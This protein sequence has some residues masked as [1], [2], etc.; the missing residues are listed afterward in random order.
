MPGFPW[1]QVRQEDVRKPEGKSKD[2]SDAYSAGPLELLW[3]NKFL[4]LLFLAAWTELVPESQNIIPY[5][6]AVLTSVLSFLLMWLI[7]L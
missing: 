6:S 1:E 5:Q 3:A 2:K 4:N 7:T